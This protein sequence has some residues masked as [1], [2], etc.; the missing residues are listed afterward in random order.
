VSST[1]IQTFRNISRY[2]LRKIISLIYQSLSRNWLAFRP[3]RVLF[4][5]GGVRVAQSLVFCVII[6]CISVC[7]YVLCFC[8]YAVCPSTYGL[9]SAL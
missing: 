8:H 7:A 6:L 5:S 2:P 3:I 1:A 4:L 9:R